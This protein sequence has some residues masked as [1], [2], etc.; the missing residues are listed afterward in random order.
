MHDLQPLSPLGATEPSRD[1]IGPVTI[2]EVCDTALA[3]VAAR[4]GKEA[5]TQEVLAEMIGANAPA[6]SRHAGG[7]LSAFWTGPDQWMV[8]APHDTHEEL[9]KQLAGRFAELASVTEQTD[10]WCRFDLIGDQLGSVLERLC[11]LIRV[12]GPAERFNAVA[13]II[14]DVSFC[15]ALQSTYRSLARAVLPRHC[16]T[17]SSSR[18][19]QCFDQTEGTGRFP[20]TRY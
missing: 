16:I 20:S 11:R 12:A 7:E 9:A 19:S 3:S 2:T 8:E 4:L 5:A 13:S 6:P 10:A 14:W 17:H 15:A 1:V 18:A